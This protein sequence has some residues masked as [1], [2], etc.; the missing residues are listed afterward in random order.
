MSMPKIDDAK[1]VRVLVTG[2]TGY[3][4]GWLIKRLLDA[5]AVVNATVRDPSNTAKIAHLQA[6]ADESP[7]SIA[8]FKADLLQPGSHDRAMRDCKIVFHTASPFLLEQEVKSPQQDLVEPAV[9]GTTDVLESANRTP[10]VERVVLTSSGAAIAGGP[11]DFAAA[12]GGVLTEE[13]WNTVSSLEHGP[14]LY[15]KTLAERTAWQ[16]ANAQKRWRL[17]VIN[18]GLVLGPGTADVQTSASFGHIRALSDGTYLNKGVPPIALTMVD[19]RDVAE[20][21]FRAG[22]IKEAEGRHIVAAEMMPLGQLADM[23]RE[24]F[25]DSWAFAKNVPLPAGI[26]RARSSNAKSKTALGMDYRP[27]K[28]ALIAMFSQLVDTGVLKKP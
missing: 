20:A 26:P 4:A 11:A 7:G 19:V 24:A 6:M 5:G 1:G 28:P 22:F 8:F 15:S 13:C 23:L 9:K 14:Y 3:V 17:V 18:P 21:H 2:A 27:I 10:S 25:G 12:P 16:I